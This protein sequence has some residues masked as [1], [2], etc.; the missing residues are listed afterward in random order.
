MMKGKLYQGD[1]R[2][3]ISFP[4]GGIGAGCI[5]L[6]GYGRLIDWEIFNRPNKRS[7]NGYSHFAVKAEKNGELLDARILNADA[8]PGYMGEGYM[9]VSQ[10]RRTPMPAWRANYGFGPQRE[11]L[12]GMPHFRDCEFEGAF[13]FAEIHFSDEAFPGR[14]SLNAFNPYIPLDDKN[15]SLPAAFFTLTLSNSQDE[16]IDYTAALS[17][18]NP[19]LGRHFNRLFSEGGASGVCLTDDTAEGDPR[20]GQLVMAVDEKDA[21]VCQQYWFRGTWFDDLSLFWHDFAVPGALK[22][23][24]YAE[25]DDSEWG[26]WGG[27][28]DTATLSVRV[29]LRPG[30]T[31]AIRFAV[32]WYYP[33]CDCYWSPVKDDEACPK[34]WKNYYAS[35]FDSARAVAAYALK[36]W[37]ALEAKTRLFAESLYASDLPEAALDAVTANISLLKSPTCM[38]LENGEFYAFEGCNMNAGSCEGSC[39]HVWNYAFALPFLFPAL[40]RSMRELD[41]GYNQNDDGGMVFRLR[42]PLGRARGT[43]RSCVD[44][45]MGGVIKFYREW[46]LCG[47]EQWLRAWWPRVK[48]S[49]EYAW[50]PTNADRWDPDKTGVITGRQHH[51]L[52][53]EL[54]GPNAWLNTFYLAAL[55]AGSEIAAHLGETDSA[56]EYDQLYRQGR[57]FTEKELFNGEYFIQK[58]DLTDKSVLAPFGGST[59]TGGSVERTYW[60]DESGEIKYQIQNGCGID[61]VLAQWM[62]DVSG[63]GEILDKDE[64]T[65]ALQAIHRHNFKRELRAH[66]NPC[67]VYGLNDESGTVICEWPQGVKKPV[68]PIPYAEETM[69]GFEYQA[70]S[71]LIARGFERE[72]LAMVKAVRD[73]YD[74]RRRNP[75]NEMECGSNYARSMAS[76]ALLPIYSGFVFDMPRR[77]MG[78]KPLKGAGRFFWS[79]EG[80]WGTVEIGADNIRLNVL[81]GDL[82]LERFVTDKANRVKAAQLDGAS[83][84]FSIDGED[85]V[86]AAAQAL[87]EGQTLALALG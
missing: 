75:W 83:A 69:H 35:Q 29:T 55:K 53:M 1:F 87:C 21:P 5:G 38:R 49:L 27:R 16:S 50:A 47:D 81:S 79:L 61:Q 33:T 80:A 10:S 7:V 37:D 42:L 19:Q 45:L 74:G 2:R 73:R 12:G 15:S 3:E 71:H 60:N 51:T 23:R 9:D 65:S 11:L 6:D 66:A 86:F 22:N 8:A 28:R 41:Y 34:T 54:F 48:K 52:D 82:T 13:P 46:K 72:G 30:E 67:R 24:L 56:A 77:R 18:S 36:N 68:V 31:R 59:L 39:T 63:L 43:F 20:Y 57:A 14:V 62:S 40:E 64:V 70:A 76:Y 84:A 58:I 32:G 4:L 25:D 85:V 17:L 44:G 26:N 78:F